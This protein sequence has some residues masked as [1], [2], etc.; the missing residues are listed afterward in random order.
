MEAVPNAIYAVKALF[1]II[2]SSTI[3]A[4]ANTIY[5]ELVL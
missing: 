3:V 1:N 2:S 4:S 5:A